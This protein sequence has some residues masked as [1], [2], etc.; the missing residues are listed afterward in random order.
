MKKFAIVFSIIVGALLLYFVGT[1]GYVKY[2]LYTIKKDTHE[3]LINNK[4]YSEDDIYKIDSKIGVG[5][6][7]QATVIF[8]DEKYHVYDYEKSNGK[9]KQLFPYPEMEQD[10]TYKHRE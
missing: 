9:I 6:K 7:Y 5:I 3:Y 8:E 10:D 4:N 1:Y 2:Q